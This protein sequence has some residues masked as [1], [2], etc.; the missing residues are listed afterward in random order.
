MPFRL[1]AWFL[2]RSVQLYQFINMKIK[3]TNNFVFIKR[4]E[5]QTETGGLWIPGQGR[6][7]PHTGEIISIGKLVKDPDIKAGKG[8]KALFHKG[9]GFEIEYSEEVY[10]V[11]SGEEIIAVV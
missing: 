8:K 9:I 7:K 3:A 10:L 6:E 11:L 1:Q 2:P 4:D 5:V